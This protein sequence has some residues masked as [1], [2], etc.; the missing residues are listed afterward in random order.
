MKKILLFILIISFPLSQLLAQKL[1]ESTQIGKTDS[2]KASKYEPAVKPVAN[3]SI[4]TR[5]SHG[6]IRGYKDGYFLTMPDYKDI[7]RG[8]PEALQQIKMANFDYKSTLYLDFAGAFAFTYCVGSVINGGKINALWGV[9]LAAGAAAVGFGFTI[10]NSAK[11]HH[12]KAIDIYNSPF[13]TPRLQEKAVLKI[14]LTDSGLGFAYR[15]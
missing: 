15:F 9:T 12:R 10:N 8:N 13:R 6:N 4:L 14:G 11:I 1:N 3:D 7:F 5:I 2:L